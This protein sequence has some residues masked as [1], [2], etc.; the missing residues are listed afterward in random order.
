MLLFT[1]H[2]EHPHDDDDSYCKIC[3]GLLTSLL[4]LHTTTSCDHQSK[5]LDTV[6]LN[7]TLSSSWAVSLWL[8]YPDR[9]SS[10]KRHRQ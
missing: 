2:F 10:G 6:N 7:V 8:I 3:V 1:G 9:C 4:I 5:P